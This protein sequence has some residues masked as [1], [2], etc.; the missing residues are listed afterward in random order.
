M[1]IRGS[2]V[3]SGHIIRKM[4]ERILQSLQWFA[5]FFNSDSAESMNRMMV[6]LCG[7]TATVLSVGAL[8]LAL[9]GLLQMDYVFLTLSIWAATF[10]GKNWSKNIEMKFGKNKEVS[11]VNEG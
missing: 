1:D 8:I 3:D 2:R 10:G 7:V 9:E 5:R 6:F 11:S 4:K